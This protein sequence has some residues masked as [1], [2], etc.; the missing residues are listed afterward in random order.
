M[1][2]CLYLSIVE[3]TLLQDMALC[4][5]IHS[6]EEVIP[7]TSG[8]GDNDKD[9]ELT[10]PP[11]PVRDDSDVFT[12]ADGRRLMRELYKDARREDKIQ[13]WKKLKWKRK[14]LR[15]KVSAV[16]CRIVRLFFQGCF[17]R[18]KEFK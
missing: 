12:E 13:C 10:T 17:R 14:P 9:N 15:V 8:Y 5:H 6:N 7:F 4:K 16:V 2:R 1:G 3:Y 18:G 11:L